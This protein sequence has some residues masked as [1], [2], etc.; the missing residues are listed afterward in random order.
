MP[1]GSCEPY[2]TR[3]NETTVI[4]PYPA[5]ELVGRVRIDWTVS[6]RGR[7]VSPASAPLFVVFGS[8]S[9][10]SATRPEALC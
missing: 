6:G 10:A 2:G 4:S 9:M 7:W 1:C 8:R 3:P 5:Q